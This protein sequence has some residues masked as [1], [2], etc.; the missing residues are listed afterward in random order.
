MKFLSI[1]NVGLFCFCQLAEGQVAK[2]NFEF[3]GNHIFIKVG[4][5][6]SDSLLFVFDSGATNASIDSATAENAGVSKQSREIVNVG[7]HGG[8]QSYVMARDQTFRVA[9]LDIEGVDPMLINFDA[10]SAETGL[11]IDGLIG[12]ELLNRYITQIDFDNK[13]MLFYHAITDVKVAGYTA[14]PFEFNKGILIPRFPVTIQL[15]SG[16]TFTGRVMFDCGGAFTLLVSTPFNK[17]HQIS[18]KLPNRT[19][20]QGRGLNTISSE[21][22]DVIKGMS[23]NGFELGQM[24]IELT[25]NDKAEPKDGYLGMI[26]I[27]IIKRFNVILDYANKMIYLKPNKAYKDA[28]PP[29]H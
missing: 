19:K 24:P 4:T 15:M 23:F 18:E 17:F 13:E 22:V 2:T 25:I 28:F 20:K 1:I 10:F 6:K 27:D 3:K 26:G 14:I 7:G 11:K 21:E 16:E 8:S 12:Y 9:G 29:M 5:G